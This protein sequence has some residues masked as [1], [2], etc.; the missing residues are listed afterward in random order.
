M[1]DYKALNLML[2]GIEGQ[3]LK[4]LSIVE[5]NRHLN[6]NGYPVNWLGSTGDNQ[7]FSNRISLNVTRPR[8]GL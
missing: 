6:F 8:V 1:P 2:G 3:S 5:G 4:K 7:L